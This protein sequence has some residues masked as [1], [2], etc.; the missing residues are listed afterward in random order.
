M[1]AHNDSISFPK[2]SSM[3]ENE[4]KTRSKRAFICGLHG[5]LK[6]REISELWFYLQG[7]EAENSRMFF[8]WSQKGD[9]QLRNSFPIIQLFQSL[10]IFSSCC[11]GSNKIHVGCSQRHPG[12]SESYPHRHK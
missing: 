2:I 1:K 12:V 3:N 5:Q 11:R 10:D 6:S 8:L 9:E 4:D 7:A